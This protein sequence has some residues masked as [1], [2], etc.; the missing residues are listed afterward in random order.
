MSITNLRSGAGYVQQ[1]PVFTPEDVGSLVDREVAARSVAARTATLFSTDKDSVVFPT[2]EKDPAVGWFEELDPIAESDVETGE[3][4]VTIE[5][6]AGLVL[7]S[8]ELLSDSSPEIAPMVGAGLSRQI[9]RAV[10]AAYL[11]ST[12]P[13]APNGLLSVNYSSVDTGAGITNLDPFVEARYLAESQ[14][15]VLTSW[16]VSPQVA[17]TLS[18]L[19]IQDGS[20]QSLLQFVADG[21]IN[22]VGLPVVVSDQ[23]DG[24]TQFFGIPREHVILVARLGTVVEKFPDV[25]RYGTWVRAVARYG[26]GFLNPAGIVRGYATA[27]V[28]LVTAKP[29]KA[30]SK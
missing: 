23:V 5:K 2:W 30:A 27:A 19:K 6:T 7:S 24:D 9:A 14:G 4:K 12:T 11:N 3:V 29:A 15:S 25:Q 8:T 22:I 13:K 17:E 18:K 20:N 10:D 28:P 21:S 26:I 16:I 1:S